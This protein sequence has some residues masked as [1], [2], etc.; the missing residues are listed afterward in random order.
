VVWKYDFD[1]LWYA[2]VHGARGGSSLPP[3]V[4]VSLTDAT[5]LPPSLDPPRTALRPRR[6]LVG[7]WCAHVRDVAG[8]VA[9]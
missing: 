1:V 3:S 2:R 7:L 4:C 6:R 9:V 5:Y 8:P